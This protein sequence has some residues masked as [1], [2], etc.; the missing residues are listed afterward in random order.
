MLQTVRLV[1]WA[2]VGCLGVLLSGCGPTANT[3]TTYPV[4][5]T[6]KVDGTP[7]ASGRII[8][9]DVAR[10][11]SNPVNIVNGEYDGQ[12]ASGDVKARVMRIEK[13][14]NPMSNEEIETEI[15]LK[16]D[17]P[18]TIQTSSNTLPPIDITAGAP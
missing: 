17:I 1:P 10:S 16:G 8:F 11:I 15:L 12:A 13:T 2:V 5:G 7:L 3:A 4:K 9:E 14:K 6:V 18:I